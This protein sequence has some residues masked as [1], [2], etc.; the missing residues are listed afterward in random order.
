MRYCI[1]V[2]LCII[3]ISTLVLAML[4]A[5]PAGVNYPEEKADAAAYWK[6]NCI[7][8]KCHA[9]EPTYDQITY[10]SREYFYH[11]GTIEYKHGCNL[12]PIN[13]TLICYVNAKGLT[14]KKP[15]GITGLVCLIFASSLCGIGVVAGM[16]WI[17]MVV[18]ETI[19]EHHSTTAIPVPPLTHAPKIAVSQAQTREDEA[20]SL[21][22]TP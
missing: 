3:I 11:E 21:A 2:T 19:V 14:L 5:I 12:H 20:V 22:S 16:V 18:V 9:V 8:T 10:E 4:F 6:T 1:H 7:V 17:L 13:S 15:G